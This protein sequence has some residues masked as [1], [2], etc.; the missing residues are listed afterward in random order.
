MWHVRSS[1]ATQMVPA[2]PKPPRLWLCSLAQRSPQLR[3]SFVGKGRFQHSRFIGFNLG[4]HLVFGYVP[5]EHEKG[6]RALR[7]CLGKLLYEVVTD[8]V[9]CQRTRQG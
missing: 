7:D 1:V 5:E 8:P 4:K 3:L 9:V 6:R 2:A